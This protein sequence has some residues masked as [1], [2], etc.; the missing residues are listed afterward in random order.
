ML[1]SVCAK[2]LLKRRT[3]VLFLF[4]DGM[5]TVISQVQEMSE[6]Q[7]LQVA[8]QLGQEWKQVAIYL[9]LN[10]KDLD[11]IQASEKNV[12]MQKL[13]ML[14]VWKS[15]RQPTEATVGHLWKSV[16]DLD[17]LPNEARQTLQGNEVQTHLMDPHGHFSHHIQMVVT[18]AAEPEIL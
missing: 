11:D 12:T 1:V 10:S 4:L 6:K 7:L 9:D 18:E 17:V 5:K 2:I 15:R 14:V 8:K 13:K 3:C 16:K